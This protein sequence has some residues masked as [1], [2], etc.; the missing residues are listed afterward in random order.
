[1]TEILETPKLVVVFGGAGFIGRH[2]VRALAMR[3]YRIRVGCRRPDLAGHLQ[4][5]GNVGQIQPVQANLRVRWS[6]DRAVEGADHVVNLVGILHE[7]GRQRFTT[8]HQFGAHA[9]AEAARAIGAGLTHISALGA[10]VKSGSA[11]ARSKALGERAVFSTI[12][13]AVVLRPSIAFGPEDTFFNRFA[14]MA[15][16]SPALPLIGGGNTRFQPTYAADI[17]EVVARSVD[18]EVAGGQVYELGGPNVLTFKECMEELLTITDRKRLLVPVPWWV[19]NF[20][21]SILGLLPNP[22]LTRDQVTQLRSHNVV[23]AEAIKAGRTFAGLGIQPQAIGTILPSY[24]WRFRAAG[25]FQRKPA[26]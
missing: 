3:G 15:R 5:L 14:A 4:P 20:Q 2:V 26:G 17:A 6:V 24:L 25:Q 1:M 13:G 23:S 8:V 21:A 19:A 22:L 16:V 10:D 12:P 11:Y 7:S 18:G 9:V